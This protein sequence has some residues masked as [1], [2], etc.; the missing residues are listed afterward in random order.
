MLIVNN[1]RRLRLNNIFILTIMNIRK[2][3]AVLILLDKVS[4]ILIFRKEIINVN[5][6]V[7]SLWN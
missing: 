5:T 3:K 4:M 7:V 2:S 1:P 6:D